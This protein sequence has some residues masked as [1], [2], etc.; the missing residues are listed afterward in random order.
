MAS[1]VTSLG[2]C[3]THWKQMKHILKYIRHVEDIAYDTQPPPPPPLKD[4][5]Q[6]FVHILTLKLY[7]TVV[8]QDTLTSHT[9]HPHTTHSTPSLR[10]PLTHTTHPH[11]PHSTPSH[12]T[13]LTHTTHPHL[14]HGTP[15]HHV[16]QPSPCTHLTLTPR[17][18]QSHN[19][20]S[21]P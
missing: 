13:P 6:T 17:T 12:H 16:Q 2:L 7:T 10:T 21:I 18:A 5:L 4:T 3:R 14:P 8:T 15:S 11:L 20:Y 19:T 9:A 1:T